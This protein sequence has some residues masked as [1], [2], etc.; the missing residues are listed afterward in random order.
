MQTSK[1]QAY[2]EEDY[3]WDDRFRRQIH[4]K[5]VV[6]V[7]KCRKLKSEMLIVDGKCSTQ[8]SLM[9]NGGR[10]RRQ[11]DA[12]WHIKDRYRKWWMQ[13]KWGYDR[14]DYNHRQNWRSHY[15]E[16]RRTTRHSEIRN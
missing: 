10:Y 5:G 14:R 3:P 1:N 6:A 13:E 7:D 11:K 16:R 12:S 9:K 8:R 15:D 2:C 4:W